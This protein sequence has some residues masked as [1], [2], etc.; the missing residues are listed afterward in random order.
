MVSGD[1]EFFSSADAVNF[2]G[3]VEGSLP[4]ML[5]TADKLSA[6]ELHRG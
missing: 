3:M 5:V 1:S 2:V 4:A 6:H